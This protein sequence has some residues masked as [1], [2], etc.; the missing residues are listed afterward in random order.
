MNRSISDL[1]IIR[2][3]FL[4]GLLLLPG[5]FSARAQWDFKTHYFKIHIDT[6]G[7]ITSMKNSTVT[8]NREF[9]ADKPSP[10]LSL[11]NYK[12]GNY[13]YPEK[14]TYSKSESQFTIGYPNGSVAT[15]KLESLPKYFRLTLLSLTNREKITDI[16]WGS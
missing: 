13:Y 11:Y 9:A 14:A 8:P 3:T 10:L 2:L 4:L 12:T 5:C 7:Y 16:Q 6:K 15:V 1:K